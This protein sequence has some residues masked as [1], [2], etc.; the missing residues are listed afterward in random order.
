MYR[1]LAA[2]GAAV[3]I[4]APASAQ[5]ARHF[6]ADAL[7]GELVVTA[8]PQIT[9]NKQPAQL[10]PAA[11][12]RGQNNLLMLSAS[13]VGQRFLV[14]YTVDAQGQVSNVWVLTAQEAANRPWPRTFTEAQRWSFDPIAQTW[15]KP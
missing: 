15:K 8:P 6:P 3:C 10:A 9:V 5:L 12:I 13:L 1:C 4:A 2:A 7:R 11:R 14:H